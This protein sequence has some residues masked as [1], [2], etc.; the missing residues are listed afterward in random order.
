MGRGDAAANGT[1]PLRRV[2]VRPPDPAALRAWRAYGWRAAP[3][4]EAIA[5]EHEAFRAALAEAGAEV[6][7]GEAPV[8]GDPDAVY[9]CDPVL[10]GPEGA[11]LLRPGKP[12][13]RAEPGAMARDLEAAGVPV[14]GRLEEPAAAEG[15]DLL[16]LDDR[17]LVA[18]HGYR[19][20][21]EGI[22]ALRKLLPGVEVVSVDLPHH[23]GPGALLHLR[24]LISLLARDL[25]VVY[26]PLMPVRM[27]QLLQDR[28]IERIEVPE[29]ELASHATNVLA[30]GPRLGLA[31]DGNPE[32]RRRMETAGVEVRTYRGDDLSVKGDGGP[33]CLTLPLARG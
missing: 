32:T 18:G 13:R 20:N 19:T 2:L 5:A 1:G 24:S 9:A 7:V 28:G 3:D 25:A 16:W 21:D 27:V 31:L 15:G 22:E 23:R 8:P 26:P 11:V 10:M 30:L 12:G 17:T 29:E 4:P 6:V 14:V 33:T